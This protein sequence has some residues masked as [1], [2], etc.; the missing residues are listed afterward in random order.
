LFAFGVAATMLR[1]LATRRILK[2]SGVVVILLGL[3]M[4]NRGLSLSGAGFDLNTLLSPASVAGKTVQKNETPANV[5]SGP[6][7][8]EIQMN[9]TRYGWTPNQFVL[10][11]GVPVR[12]VIN[13]LEVTG[14]NRAIQVPKFGLKFD[15][16]PG[17]QTI[18]FTPAEAGTVPWSCWM[19]MIPGTF[20]V[21]DDIINTNTNP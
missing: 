16:K 12:W 15:V 1:G 6:R 7:Y 14:C 5:V 21:E 13:G 4:L 18:E 9:V 20:I 19:G 17:L 10:K 8:Q 3:V 2:F 11:K